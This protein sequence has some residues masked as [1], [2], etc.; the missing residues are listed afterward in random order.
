[1]LP[2]ASRTAFPFPPC[3]LLNSYPQCTASCRCC[4]IHIAA[5]FGFYDAASE[6]LLG[7]ARVDAVDGNGWRP[8]HLATRNGHVDVAMGLL[9][10]HT[11]LPNRNPTQT[12]TLHITLTR[13]R[14]SPTA[15]NRHGCSPLQ[16]AREHAQEVAVIPYYSRY[17]PHGIGFQPSDHQHELVARILQAHP[18]RACDPTQSP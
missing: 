1:M 8:L 3:T 11:D 14:A 5:E 6:L 15:P 10:P 13:A 12:L 4:P 18:I 2:T 9:R 7:G 17:P 16:I